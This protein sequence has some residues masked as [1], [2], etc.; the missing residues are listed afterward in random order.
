MPVEMFRET[1]ACRGDISLF[2]K[3]VS[4]LRT[5]YNKHTSVRMQYDEART[6]QDTSA[7]FCG[8]I[9]GHGWECKE[10]Q[11]TLSGIIW[12]QHECNRI[13]Q[14][15][16]FNTTMLPLLGQW[17]DHY[18]TL[19]NYSSLILQTC[20]EST[21]CIHIQ[22][23]CYTNIQVQY[24]HLIGSRLWQPTLNTWQLEYKCP[25]AKSHRLHQLKFHDEDHDKG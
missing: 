19:E 18:D 15:W 3:F 4:S 25:Q 10:Y 7:N 9:L 12:P 14:F 5:Q 13:L 11:T 17:Y 20:H 22:S 21:I 8:N 24:Q 23:M 2:P 6:Q 1:V 16:A